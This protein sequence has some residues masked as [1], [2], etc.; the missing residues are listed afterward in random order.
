MNGITPQDEDYLHDSMDSIL[1]DYELD[2]K[3]CDLLVTINVESVECGSWESIEYEDEI[4][5]PNVIVLQTNFKEKLRNQI[6]YIDKKITEWSNNEDSNDETEPF[7][8]QPINCV[9]GKYFESLEGLK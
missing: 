5:F 4:T 8:C 3:D 6:L 9:K 2:E 1:S 7:L